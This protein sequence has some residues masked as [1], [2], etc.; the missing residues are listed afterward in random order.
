MTINHMLQGMTMME[1]VCAEPEK[2]IYALNQFDIGIYKVEFMDP[3]TVHFSIERKNLSKLITLINSRGEKIRIIG[4]SGL[5]CKFRKAMQRPLLSAGILVLFLLS[6]FLP[7]RV[8]FVRVEGNEQVPSRLIIE[9][10]EA[11]GIRFGA[12]RR[13]VRSE[14][15]KNALLGTIPE[16]QWAGVNTSGCVAVISVRERMDTVIHE[17]DNKTVSGIFASRDGIITSCIVTKGTALCSPG[18]AVREGQL[19][20]SGYTDCGLFLRAAKAEGE[21]FASTIRQIDIVTPVTQIRKEDTKQ[22]RKTISLLIGKNRINLCKD[23][24]ISDT[25]CD[26]IYKEY[27]LTLPGDFVLPVGVAV[28]ETISHHYSM[29]KA[30]LSSMEKKLSKYA[31]HYLQN[32][33]NAGTIFRAQKDISQMGGY[34]WLSGSYDCVEMI[35]KVQ[36]EKTG[37]IYG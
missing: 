34:Y 17:K 13:E 27:Y 18:Q 26:R 16:L 4:Q 31:M 30:E 9:R 3:L 29:E 15:T 6:C 24:G 33:M 12:S 8:L 32:L 14:K 10:A 36:Q 19:L 11:C 20:V 35:G 23:S 1:L 2:T 37:D 22:E 21:I 5:F 28:E 7:T 25:T